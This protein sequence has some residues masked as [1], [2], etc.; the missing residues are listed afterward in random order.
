MA[1]V[2]ACSRGE[3]AAAWTLWQKSEGLWC[4]QLCGENQVSTIF[5]VS[6]SVFGLSTVLN[7]WFCWQQ[8]DGLQ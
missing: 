1:A 3:E 7:G 8:A 4:Q 6:A 5:L 2:A